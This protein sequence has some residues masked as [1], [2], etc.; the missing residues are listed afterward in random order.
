MDELFLGYRE[1]EN[2]H[3]WVEGLEITIE[4]K[5][6]DELKLFKIGKLNLKGKSKEW[7]KKLTIIPTD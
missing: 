7:L 1:F 6:I 5:G 4:V 3:D 2:I